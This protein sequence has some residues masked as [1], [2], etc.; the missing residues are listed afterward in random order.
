[1][2]LPLRYLAQT[3][4]CRIGVLQNWG[5]LTKAL[6]DDKACE[7]RGE[8]AT[9]TLVLILEAAVQRAAGNTRHSSHGSKYYPP[10]P[11]RRPVREL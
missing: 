11:P 7:A 1:M 8:E 6:L 9:T 3:P 4:A 2:I 5:E 10:P